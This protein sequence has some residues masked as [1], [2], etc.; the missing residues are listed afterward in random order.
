LVFYPWYCPAIRG[1]ILFPGLTTERQSNLGQSNDASETCTSLSQ[2]TMF[3]PFYLFAFILIA[4][5]GR[6]GAF[7]AALRLMQ[8]GR[9]SRE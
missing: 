4:A 3:L 9:R 8:M 5:E 6:A 1:H 7:I 2:S